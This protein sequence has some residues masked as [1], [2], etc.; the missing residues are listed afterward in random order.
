MVL[1]RTRTQAARGANA[2]GGPGSGALLGPLRRWPA[3]TPGGHRP[4]RREV[5]GRRPPAAPAVGPPARGGGPGSGR[6]PDAGA[7]GGVR[8]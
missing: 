1:R 7:D 2:G 6:G 3:A 5:T 4:P 8:A